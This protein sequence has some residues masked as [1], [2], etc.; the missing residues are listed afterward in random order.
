M[1]SKTF[2]SERTPAAES[3]ATKQLKLFTFLHDIH[4]K[5]APAADLK[6]N[7]NIPGI[8]FDNFLQYVIGKSACGRLRHNKNE[9]YQ[10]SLDFTGL[11]R[12]SAEF[13]GV[14]KNSYKFR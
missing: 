13:T 8:M 3:K 5:K 6:G 14:H 4:L 11:H 7:K 10:T 9:V 12:T 1:F 2:Q